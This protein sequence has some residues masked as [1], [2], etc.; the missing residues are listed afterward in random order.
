[1][2]QRALPCRTRGCQGV[3]KTPKGL[4]MLVGQMS[5]SPL[6]YKCRGCGMSYRLHSKDYNRLPALDNTG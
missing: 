1:M 4:P 6:I 5:S 2:S 3:A